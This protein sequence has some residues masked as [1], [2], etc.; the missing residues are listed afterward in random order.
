[1]LQHITI[2]GAGT[3]GGGIAIGCLAAG[4]DVTVLDTSEA[5]LDRL[6]TRVAAHLVRQ[7]DKG[8][9]SAD[10]AATQTARL[11]V[12]RDLASAS[13]ADLV[14]EAVFEDL[15]IK[16]ALFRALAPHLSD[17]ALVA[18]NTS[19]LRVADLA[20][21][22]PLPARFLGLH[23][24]SPAEVNPLVE[25][26]SGPATAPDTIQ[27]AL[28]FVRATGK[29]ALLC[30]DAPGFAVNRFFCPYTNEAVRI[31]QEGLAD[32]GSIDAVACESF[33]LA[34][35]PFAVMNIIKPRINLHAVGNLAALGEFYEP[36][37]A[38]R[39]IGEADANWPITPPTPLSAALTQTIANRLRAA[40]FLPVLEALGEDVAAPEDFDLGASLALRFGQGPVAQMRALGG[41]QTQTLVDQLCERYGAAFPKIGFSR[42]FAPTNC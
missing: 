13:T 18:T 21:S 10:A 23:Y 34:F 7:I 2:C 3:M 12:S 14:I 42:V 5:A 19:A 16:R 29:T 24:F 1:M 26:V 17:T 9:I 32:T 30:R 28:A 8:R 6:R 27:A 15:E 39:K 22:L 38:L 33:G 4:L 25:V 35:G 37:Q 20:A 11:A 41:P 31:L 40:L 36:A